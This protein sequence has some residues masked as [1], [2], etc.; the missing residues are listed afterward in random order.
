MTERMITPDEA[1][2]FCPGASSDAPATPSARSSRRDL[3]RRPLEERHRAIRAAGIT[4]D[5]DEIEAW[6]ETAGDG[7]E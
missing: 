7:L 6:D 4:V 5:T 2:R 1:D 3:A